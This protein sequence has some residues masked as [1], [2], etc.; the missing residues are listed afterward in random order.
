MQVQLTSIFVEAIEKFTINKKINY[1]SKLKSFCYTNV[2]PIGQC[3]FFSFKSE[4]I[5]SPAN[6]FLLQKLR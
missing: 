6:E 1:A 2:E 4:K 5:T 3:N